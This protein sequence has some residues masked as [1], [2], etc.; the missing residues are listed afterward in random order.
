MQTHGYLKLCCRLT[1]LQSPVCMR[2]SNVLC[3]LVALQRLMHTGCAPG[4][5]MSC[6]QGFAMSCAYWLLCN[7]LCIPVVHRALQCL[8]HT[9]CAQG[10]AMSCAY[11]LLCNVL[12]IPG[13][14]T[15]LYNTTSDNHVFTQ[16]ILIT[17][18]VINALVVHAKLE[19]IVVTKVVNYCS[20][21]KL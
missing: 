5:A 11:W 18:N 13:L 3:I 10:F 8:V 21:A 2:P 20:H 9:G 6:A 15:G 7:V 17:M 4:F 12:C 14:C 1:T 19:T 16:H